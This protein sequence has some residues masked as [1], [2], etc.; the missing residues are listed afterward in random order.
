MGAKWVILSLLLVNAA[1]LFSNWTLTQS[2]NALG[3]SKRLAELEVRL[4]R[5]TNRLAAER[6]RFAERSGLLIDAVSHLGLQNFTNATHTF[7]LADS[8]V[9]RSPPNDEMSDLLEKADISEKPDPNSMPLMTEDEKVRLEALWSTLPKLSEGPL[10]QGDLDGLISDS[11]WNS[12][13]RKLDDQE[14]VQ[15]KKLLDDY[16]YYARVSNVERFKTM[17]EPQLPALREA[18]A[19]VEYGAK[20]APES[21]PGVTIS[22][23]EIDETGKSRLYYFHSEDHP[24]I[25]RSKQVCDE[26][27]QE[28]F[29]KIYNLLNG[30]RDE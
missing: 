14:R 30:I 4:S 21:L 27:S 26:R 19:F 9:Q 28:S 22:H 18:G 10:L 17:I 11:S 1:L 24:D 23:A 25:Y 2:V 7:G 16:R 6:A 12:S 3:G 8:G 5:E 20:E 13:G 15:A 29:I